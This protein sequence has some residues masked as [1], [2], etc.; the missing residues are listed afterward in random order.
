MSARMSLAGVTVD[1]TTEEIEKIVTA[2]RVEQSEGGDGPH[3]LMLINELCAAYETLFEDLAIAIS[4]RDGVSSRFIERQHEAFL[5]ELVNY[6][7][8]SR[9]QN[10]ELSTAFYHFL[11]MGPYQT[12]ALAA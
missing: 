10:G 3:L 11:E 2:L 9:C 4:D 5:S 1:T 7:D 8:E 6:A 12:S